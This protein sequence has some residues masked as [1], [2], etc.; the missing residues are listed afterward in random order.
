MG[1]PTRLINAAGDTVTVYGTMQMISYFAEGW[2]RVIDGD[3]PSTLAAPPTLP[4]IDATDAAIN[5][6]ADSGVNLAALTGSGKGGR[7]TIGDVR[8]ALDDN[9]S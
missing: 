1:E 4:L 5:L 2:R 6:A 8:A 7:I 9:I 3:E